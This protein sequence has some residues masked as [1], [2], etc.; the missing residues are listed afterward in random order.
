MQEVSPAQ[1]ANEG[2]EQGYLRY[3]ARVVL[4]SVKTD[5]YLSVN[6]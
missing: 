3:G 6:Q 5:Y 1:Q 2:Q 4:K